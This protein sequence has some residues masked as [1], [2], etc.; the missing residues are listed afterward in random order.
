MKILLKIATG[1]EYVLAHGPERV[2]GQHVGPG[3]VEHVNSVLVDPRQRIRATAKK[4]RSMGNM[5]SD[6]A[7][8]VE[9]EFADLHSAHDYMVMYPI[10]LPREGS[11]I[12]ISRV[13]DVER[14]YRMNDAVINSLSVRQN[15][16]SLA[17][18]YN[19]SGGLLERL[20]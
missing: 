16:V 11:L 9:V 5:S 4:F 14:K 2:L 12:F 8:P 3:N 15:G 10:E 19:V 17:I 20:Q 1:T 6:F 18:T 7:I 13:D